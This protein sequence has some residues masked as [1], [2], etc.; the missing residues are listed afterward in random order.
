MSRSRRKTP[1]TGVVRCRSDRDFKER[2]HRVLR[3][4][5]RAT[6]RSTGETTDLDLR[7][8]SDV[9]LSNK[10]GKWYLPRRHFMT[11]ELF[12]KVMRK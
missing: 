3:Q 8:V 2:A 12:E 4:R 9:W 5:V 6:L 10:D 7:D 11:K 1:I